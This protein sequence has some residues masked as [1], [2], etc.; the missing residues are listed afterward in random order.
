VAVG[1]GVGLDDGVAVG[2]AVPVAVAEGLAAALDDGEDVAATGMVGFG[3]AATAANTPRPTP[4]TAASP[5]AKTRT[6]LPR[7][8]GRVGTCPL[9]HPRIRVAQR[10]VVG[11][12]AG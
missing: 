8:A 6:D 3:P 9:E 11:P 12:R 2:E 5:S 1:E 4:A 10:A 7:V